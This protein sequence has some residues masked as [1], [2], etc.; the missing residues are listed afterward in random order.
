MRRWHPL[1]QLFLTRLREFYREPAVLFWVYGFPLFLALGLGLAFSGGAPVSPQDAPPGKPE[2]DVQDEPDRSEASALLHQLEAAGIEARLGDPVACQSR[3]RTGDT[4]LV[5]VPAADRYRYV[6]DPARPGS[7]LARCQVDAVVQ[8]W[9]AGRPAWPTEDSTPA[10]PGD[11][12][13]DFL[14]PGLMG[15][16][17]MAGGLWGVGY[18]IVD[19]RVRKLL[20]R[21]LATPMRGSDFLLSLLASRLLC[22]VTEMVMLV[23]AGLLI[24]GVPVRGS[25][26]GLALVILAGAS[27]F[28]GLGLVLASRVERTETVSGLINLLVLPMWMLSGTFFS[29]HRF[30]DCFQPVVRAL[31]LTH[32][33]DALRAVMLEGAPAASVLAPAGLLAGWGVVSF[34]VALGCFSWR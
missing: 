2:V 1:W 6:Y 15:M 8:R 31:P 7:R 30:P 20:K 13:I 12:Y 24:F 21:L 33:N 4:S 32:L 9:K 3:L 26:G 27:A 5:V 16:N 29:P 18:V 28:A 34:L 17:L 22:L 23:L 19:M 11:R 25:V 14:I 10:E